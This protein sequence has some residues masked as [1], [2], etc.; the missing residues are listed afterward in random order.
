MSKYIIPVI[1][2]SIISGCSNTRINDMESSDNIIDGIDHKI[3]TNREKLQDNI[4]NGIRP[5]L[6]SEDNIVKHKAS[7]FDLDNIELMF[8]KPV[9][10]KE[11]INTFNAQRKYQ[12]YYV[13][14]C[15]V[16]SDV[17]AGADDS[18]APEADAL[19]K[20]KG[21][22]NTPNSS[23]ST[24]SQLN[25]N[26]D[27]VLEKKDMRYKGTTRG[28][29]TYIE[30]IYDV[31][32]EYIDS[33]IYKVNACENKTFKL[34]GVGDNVTGSSSSASSESGRSAGSY[35]VELKLESNR[36][37]DLI[38]DVEV[39]NTA[40]GTSI[41]NRSANSLTV[42]DKPSAVTEI[43]KKITDYNKFYSKQILLLVS[44]LRYK[45]SQVNQLGL[46]WDAVITEGASTIVSGSEFAKQI[47][48]GI[49]IGIGNST[50][51]LILKSYFSNDKNVLSTRADVLTLNG[52]PTPLSISNE[53]SYVSSV[54]T[55]KDNDNNIDTTTVEVETL[56]VGFNMMFK[57]S[58]NDDELITINAYI[59][60][61]ELLSLDPFGDISLPSTASRE[62]LQSF[63]V[64]SGDV[65]LLTGYEEQNSRE[66]E[67]SATPYTFLFG[68]SKDSKNDNTRLV[69][70][71]EP[72]IILG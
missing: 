43:A 70:L 26:S 34:A 36:I 71:I 67:N 49:N 17:A 32:V 11:V 58:A 27:D 45:E 54:T 69:I 37:D 33:G 46:D 35:S 61:N 18:A 25:T 48:S 14:N 20:I 2:A 64:N 10:V 38:A 15:A 12:G 55:E 68:G 39:L 16:T 62:F 22:V 52:I 57:A 56:V 60:Q 21:L 29:I 8:Y 1:V 3:I 63:S 23:I 53:Q 7:D 66:K 44:V 30:H 65:V 41:M 50:T 19:G 24:M 13:N 31:N 4:E 40:L 5:Q 47:T 6:I 72:K 59:S 42:I 51:D 28:L 9:T